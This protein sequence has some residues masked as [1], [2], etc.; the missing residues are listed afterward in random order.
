LERHDYL[1]LFGMRGSIKD[2]KQTGFFYI[3]IF[4]SLALHVVWESLHVELYTGYEHI[5]GLPI[6]LYA[7]LGDVLYTF[8]A[9]GVV[10]LFRDLPRALFS[11]HP[12]DYIGLAVLG[13]FISVFVEYKAFFFMRWE[14]TDAMPII[15]FLGIGLSPVLQM[16]IL[17]PLS[18]WISWYIYGLCIK[19]LPT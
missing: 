1:I 7:S 13:F 6:V 2:M 17:L 16:T 9:L 14:Y 5:T 15:P 4:V 3:L 8:L 12:R 18:V 11:M 19:R 10:A